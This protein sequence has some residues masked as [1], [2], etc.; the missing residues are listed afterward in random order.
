MK[1]STTRWAKKLFFGTYGEINVQTGSRDDATCTKTRG[2]FLQYGKESWG[3]KGG[4]NCVSEESF[5][6][7]REKWENVSSR[8]IMCQNKWD[9]LRKKGNK[10]II[11]LNW[12][13]TT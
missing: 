3:W 1:Q 2:E 10:G 12:L 11:T 13:V 5:A 6:Q 4:W 8:G 7:R 9:V